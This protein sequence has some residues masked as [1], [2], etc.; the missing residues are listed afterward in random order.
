MPKPVCVIDAPSNLGLRPPGP[1]RDPGVRRLAAALRGRGIVGRLGAEDGG[2]VGPPPYSPAW[3]GET[4]RN[5]A[6]IR[7]VSV[8][9]AGRVG[10][11]VEEGRFPLVLVGD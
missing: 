4:V 3:D 10:S 2:A 8:E 7:R 9:L 11:V 6:A 1:G 5:G